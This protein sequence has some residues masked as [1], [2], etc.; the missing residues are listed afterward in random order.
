MVG[1]GALTSLGLSA[2]EADIYLDLLHCGESRTGAI[3]E[4]TGIPSSHIYA[5]LN[6][7]MEKGLVGYKIVRNVKVF[8][9]S[10]PDSLA[11]LFD[12][13]ERKMKEEKLELLDMISKLKV[14]PRKEGK[15]GNFRY[16]PGMRGIKAL[17]TEVMNHWEAGGTLRIASAPLESFSK[18][19]GFF[20]DVVHKRMVGDNVKLRMI[21]N[22]NSRKWALK[23]KKMPLTEIRYLDAD[24]KTEMGGTKDYFFIVSYGKGPYGL[25]I[26]DRDCADTGMLFFEMLW[27]QAKS[28]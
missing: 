17:Y 20:L 3:C 18:M 16:F 19:E 1:I 21:I 6:S 2:K 27:K 10:E 25:L 13:K 22:S 28:D 12:E 7:L 23:R 26:K 5:L 11:N 4:R 15:G 14:S 8:S 9:A 24:T